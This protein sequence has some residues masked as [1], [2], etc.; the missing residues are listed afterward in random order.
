MHLMLASSYS[1]RRSPFLDQAIELECILFGWKG[2][3]LT[4]LGKETLSLQQSQNC[5][6]DECLKLT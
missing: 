4:V 3:S 2:E 6:P 1:A 5:S